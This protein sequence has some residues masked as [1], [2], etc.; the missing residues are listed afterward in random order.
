MVTL[1]EA[2]GTILVFQLLA[3]FQSV[4]VAPVHV[5]GLIV[6]VCV[7][8]TAAAPVVVTPTVAVPV[9]AISVAG[10][11]AVNCVALTKVVV[12]LAPFQVT[13][14]WPLIKFVPLTVKVKV[15]PPAP[16]EVGE[17]EVVVGVG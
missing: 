7:L 14:D 5:G 6:K 4:L 10:T 9:L 8:E 13:V 3:V 12:R 15:A 16:A 11:L 1:V 17:M 2:V